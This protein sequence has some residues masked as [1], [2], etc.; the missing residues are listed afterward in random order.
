MQG[1]A[2]ER[3]KDGSHTGRRQRRSQVITGFHLA[4]TA[5]F[6]GFRRRRFFAASTEEFDPALLQQTMGLDWAPTKRQKQGGP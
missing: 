4:A 2:D 5:F 3:A 6:T 1:R